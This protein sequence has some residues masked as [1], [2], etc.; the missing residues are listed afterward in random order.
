MVVDSSAMVALMLREPEAL[1][2]ERA[3]AAATCHMSAVNVL[4]TRIV[5]ERRVG[6]SMID[7]LERVLAAACSIA[8]FDSDQATRAFAAHRR[9]G[10]GT[11]HPAQLNLGDCAAYALATSLGLPL[12]YKGSDFS[13]TDVVAAA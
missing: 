5:L 10:K 9:F 1:A 13:K 6:A 8:A 7:H 12:L 2:F 11:G 3:I 4:E